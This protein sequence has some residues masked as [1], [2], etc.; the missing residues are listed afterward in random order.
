MSQKN[1]DICRWDFSRFDR[2]LVFKRFLKHIKIGNPD[3]CWNW[4]GRPAERSKQYA[5]FRWEE[6]RI[7]NAH[8]AAYIL[9]IGNIPRRH[10]KK[11]LCVCHSC[12]NG[13]CVNP[14]HLWLGTYKQ[15]EAD[16]YSKGR[17]N[18]ADHHGESNPSAKLTIEEVEKIRKKYATGH[19]TCE[20]LGTKFNVSKSTVARIVSGK[21]WKEHETVQ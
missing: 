15:N 20:R 10:G 13:R 17:Q 5:Y 12:D 3:E 14:N 9:F 4:D 8:V 19:Y 2:Y 7:G 16:K 6:K 1:I 21:C 18:I 11:K